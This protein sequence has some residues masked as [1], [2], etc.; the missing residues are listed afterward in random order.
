MSNLIL[1]LLALAVLAVTLFILI[2]KN[3]RIAELKVKTDFALKS[4]EL[5][6]IE[7]SGNDSVSE[8]GVNFNKLADKLSLFRKSNTELS[9]IKEEKLDLDQKIK[10]FEGSLLQMNLLTDIGRQ[11][12]SCLTV[13]DIAI[14]LFKNINSSMIV[15]EVNL[16]I[17][18]EGKK[19]YYN[20]FNQKIE[21]I[22]NA[23]WCNDPDNI[24]NWCLEN[25]KEAFLNEATTDYAQYVFKPLRMV[26]G[27]P[28]E[29]IIAVPLS[30]SNNKIGAISISCARK[31]IFNDFHLDFAR[32]VAS[33][34]SVAI[35]NA[36][37][38]GELGEEKQKSE[39]LLLNILP[40]EIAEELKKNGKTEPKQFENVT[41]L[42]TD[43]QNFTGISEKLTP[44]ELVTEL[45][46]YFKGFDEI[47]ERNGLEKIKT[48]GD[49][50][51][52]E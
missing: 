36:N 30:L 7:M 42:F 48:N 25:N 44:K 29:S 37:L 2:N 31:N 38:Y 47:A 26:G 18:S 12:T 34:V 49:A 45:D 22:D 43:F 41:V 39:E 17:L 50:Y 15:D 16:L 21:E 1:I 13:K 51:L 40:I 4:D 35:F 14:K 33:Y 6:K 23:D 9:G 10:T 20:V 24:L 52:A 46:K 19:K 32:S 28:V 11:I 8:I 27:S 5:I 3:R